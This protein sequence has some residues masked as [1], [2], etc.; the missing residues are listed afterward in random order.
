VKQHS[1]PG[2]FDQA[3]KSR[4][5]IVFSI[6]VILLVVFSFMSKYFLTVENFEAMGYGILSVGIVSIGMM[7]VMITGGFDLSVGSTLALTGLLAAEMLHGGWPIWMAIIG[8]LLLGGMIGVF[9]GIL[10]T[11]V[12]INPFI[13]TLG[14]MSM[15]RGLALAMSQGRPV[16]GLPNAFSFL[17]EGRVFGFPFA[18]LVLV[19]LVIIADQVARRTKAARLFYYVG[20]NEEAAKLSGIKTKQVRL[21]AF[22]LVGILAALAGV[23]WASRMMSM[24][25]TA[26][27]GL[28][29]KAIAACVVGGASLAGGEGT[30]IGAFLGTILIAFIDDILILMNVSSYWQLFSAGAILVAVVTLDILI[31]KIRK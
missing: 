4:P 8:A 16:S 22:V 6:D 7:I 17:G 26:G 31:R 11:R 14:T 23:I 30:I 13:A 29:L 2:F 20:G 1:L 24:M 15:V 5:I 25:P 10:I 12:K 9:N 21:A 18:I 19:L 28:E 27:N 3:L